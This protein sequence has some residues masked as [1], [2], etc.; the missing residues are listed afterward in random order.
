MPSTY[1]HYRFGERVLARLPETTRTLLEKNR[2]LYDIG[3]HG[4]DFFFFYKPL[5]KNTIQAA[6]SRMHRTIFKSFLIPAAEKIRA[7]NIKS[8]KEKDLAYILGF[9]C[10][11]ALDSA[12]HSYI[13]KKISVS[14]LRHNAI[15][16]DFERYLLEKDGKDPVKEKVID[17]ILIPSYENASVISAFFPGIPAKEILSALKQMVRFHHILYT[18]NAL[19]RNLLLAGLRITGFYGPVQGHIMRPK[20]NP[21]CADSS[22]RLYRLTELAEDLA[23]ELILSFFDFLDGKT[24]LDDRFARTFGPGSGWKS[25]PVLSPEEEAGYTPELP[26]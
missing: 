21:A 25:I 22:L 5:R 16:G 6:G 24:I 19:K 10:H 13:E 8:E 3:Q 12:T 26:E 15:E 14:G 23:V 17:G 20:P 11:Y 1:A 7:D 4:P 18:P 2:E 9:I